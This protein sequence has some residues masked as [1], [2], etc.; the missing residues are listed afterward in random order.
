MGWKWGVVVVVGGVSVY[1]GMVNVV[2]YV[3]CLVLVVRRFCG[4]VD[5]CGRVWVI[6]GLV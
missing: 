3:G 1:W 2:C 4:L 5:C 6:V